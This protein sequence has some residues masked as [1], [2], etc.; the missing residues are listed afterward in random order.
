MCRAAAAAVLVCFGLVGAGCRN[1]RLGAPAP[2]STSPTGTKSGLAV[3]SA[4]RAL[5]A[6]YLVIAA[7]GNRRLNADFD[8]LEERDLYRVNQAR[9]RLATTAAASASL[10]QLRAYEPALDAADRPVEQAVRTIRRQLGLPPPP[11]S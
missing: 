2:E 6:R 4:R 1:S 11:T 8:P 10:R 9:A 3:G 7:A 5:A